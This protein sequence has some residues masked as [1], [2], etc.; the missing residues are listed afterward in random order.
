MCVTLSRQ[1]S[2]EVIGMYKRDGDEIFVVDGHM[3]LWDASP[4]N[5]K[6]KY[7]EGWIRCFYDYQKGLSPAEEV[8]SFEK[9]CKY[10]EEALIKDLF[11]N[12]YVDMA[13]LNS[14]Y[15]YEFYK[16]GFNSHQQNHVLKQKYPDRFILCGGF[17]PR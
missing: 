12:G 3:H 8:W 1:Q 6:N 13:V 17:D 2:E 7:G 15:L 11:L 14:T 16:N 5:W 9:F 4:E 10:G